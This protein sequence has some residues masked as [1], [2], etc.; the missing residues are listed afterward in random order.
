MTSARSSPMRR[1]ES[2]ARVLRSGC[3]FWMSW[4][5]AASS[6]MSMPQRRISS[7]CPWSSRR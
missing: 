5:I 7:T 3:A 6:E 2:L 4:M 1:R